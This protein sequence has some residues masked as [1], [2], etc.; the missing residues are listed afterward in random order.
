MVCTLQERRSC[1]VLQPSGMLHWAAPTRGTRSS[2]FALFSY[3]HSAVERLLIP[4][5]D[6]RQLALSGGRKKLVTPLA[7][8]VEVATGLG[9]IRSL[10]TVLRVLKSVEDR[11]GEDNLSRK[12]MFFE[13]LN[14]RTVS[15][16]PPCR[17]K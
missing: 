2:L 4:K 11:A 10:P 9:W 3:I 1:L 17:P 6:L 13:G 8:A 5:N 15:C 7:A 16:C 12:F 14:S